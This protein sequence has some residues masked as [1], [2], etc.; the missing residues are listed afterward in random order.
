[1]R[2]VPQHILHGLPLKSPAQV[3]GAV[4]GTA[5]NQWGF[6][7]LYAHYAL[8]THHAVRLIDLVRRLSLLI[9]LPPELES[10]DWDD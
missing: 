5:T 2:F 3:N 8:R 6:A 10:E 4:S 9:F 7:S 1:M